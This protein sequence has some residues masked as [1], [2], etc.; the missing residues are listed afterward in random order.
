MVIH[1]VIGVSG[2]IAIPGAVVGI[3]VGGHLCKRCQLAARGALQLTLTL[4]FLALATCGV[5]FLLGCDNITI[6]GATRPYDNR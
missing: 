1:V 3:L 4:N 6:A 2:G 5:F